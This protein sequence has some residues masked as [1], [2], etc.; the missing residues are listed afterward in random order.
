[1]ARRPVWKWRRKAGHRSPESP[2]P[3]D[4]GAPLETASSRFRNIESVPPA[5][6][7]RDEEA[8]AGP[9]LGRARC[10]RRPDYRRGLRNYDSG[11]RI[12]FRPRTV[13]TAEG[14]LE[15]EIP[16]LREAA[17]PLRAMVIGAF[18]GGLSMRDVWVAV[19]AGRTG[20]GGE[21]DRPADLHRAQR[22]L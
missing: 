8:A 19:R 13:Q 11:L 7:L 10:E 18:V 1:M 21:V 2:D 5:L 4:P 17:E 15:I 6:L 22:A 16:Q 3:S 12:G 20:E 14:E 9:L